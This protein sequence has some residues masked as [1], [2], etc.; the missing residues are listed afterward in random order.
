MPRTKWVKSCSAQGWSEQEQPL[1]G[2]AIN[3]CVW[4]SSWRDGQPCLAPGCHYIPFF[5]SSWMPSSSMIRGVRNSRSFTYFS[6]P[7]RTRRSSLEHT[8]HHLLC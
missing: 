1:L 7:Y 2:P 6:R 3:L 4:L 8:T 5:T